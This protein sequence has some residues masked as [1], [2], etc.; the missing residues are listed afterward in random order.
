M[1]AEVINVTLT[2]PLIILINDPDSNTA[3][4]IN[5]ESIR[6]FRHLSKRLM[7]TIRQILISAV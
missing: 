2:G 7:A 5:T 6:R 1:S 3:S 4:R